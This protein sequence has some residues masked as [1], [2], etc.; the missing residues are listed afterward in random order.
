MLLIKL[1]PCFKKIKPKEKTLLVELTGL[2]GYAQKTIV[3][4]TV[5]PIKRK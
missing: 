5:K 1:N 2:A 4:D 3:T